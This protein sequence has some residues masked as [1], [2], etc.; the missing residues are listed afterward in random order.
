MIEFSCSPPLR[1]ARSFAR[2][3]RDV[4][5][6]LFPQR[7]FLP[8]WGEK[9]F[10]QLDRQRER[11]REVSSMSVE[12][13][14]EIIRFPLIPSSSFSIKNN[15]VRGISSP[16]IT[17]KIY[18]VTPAAYRGLNLGFP[19]TSPSPPPIIVSKLGN[20]PDYPSPPVLI[21]NVTDRIYARGLLQALRD[22]AGFRW[23]QVDRR[24]EEGGERTRQLITGAG[25]QKTRLC[26]LIRHRN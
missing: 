21:Y 2:V 14:S 8:R 20:A 23:L 16:A 3:K 18:H 10:P 26:K 1:F 6:V 4:V 22:R 13:S 25:K 12:C 17:S 9:I 11:E 24:K 5:R 19:P 15:S 7:F